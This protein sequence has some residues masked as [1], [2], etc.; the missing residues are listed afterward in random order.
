MLDLIPGYA[1]A[2]AALRF[3]PY[4]GMGVLALVAALQYQS[5]RHWSKL[6]LNEKAAHAASVERYKGAQ[7]V[8]AELNKAK[9]E[10]IER[11]YAVIAEKSER[12]YDALLASNRAS[13]DRWLRGQANNRNTGSSTTGQAATV[14]PEVTGAETLPV[15]PRGFVILPESDLDKTADIQ[16]TLAALQEAARKVM[17]VETVP[18]E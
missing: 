18:V 1:Q 13:L 6:A 7:R 15:I 10:R 9:V 11:E 8:A 3:L 17:A 16:A 4:I 12:N 14:Q 5:A 2:R